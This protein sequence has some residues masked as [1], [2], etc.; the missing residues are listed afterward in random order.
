MVISN[1]NQAGINAQ[2]RVCDAGVGG[3][4]GMDHRSDG[5]CA[6]EAGPIYESR[7]CGSWR[8]GESDG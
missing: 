6:L 5:G 7:G 4:M 8:E 3:G 1:G 2:G